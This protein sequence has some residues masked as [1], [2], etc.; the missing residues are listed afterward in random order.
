[1]Y[2]QVFLNLLLRLIRKAKF[3]RTLWPHFSHHYHP[4]TSP[5]FSKSTL[6]LITP[7]RS[8]HPWDMTKKVK[9]KAE[10]GSANGL[11]TVVASFVT[12]Q[13]TATRRGGSLFSTKAASSSSSPPPSLMS[14][15]VQPRISFFSHFATPLFTTPHVDS[16]APMQI[17]LAPLSLS[18]SCLCLAPPLSCL[19]CHLAITKSKFEN[20]KAPYQV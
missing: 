18:L 15:V 20:G 11:I 12:V 9:L 5:A 17:F 1:M 13:S 14:V 16:A 3:L 10:A 2:K 19:S 8:C 6:T 4:I 7:S